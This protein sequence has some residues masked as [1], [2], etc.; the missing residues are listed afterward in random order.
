MGTET[1]RPTKYK[2]EYCEKVIEFLRDGMSK[3]EICRELDIARSTLEEWENNQPLFSEAI[4]KGVELS[5]GWWEK[6]GR[7][8]LYDKDFNTTLWLANMRNRF[9]ADWGV[10]P[11][12]QKTVNVY[13]MDPA[14]TAEYEAAKKSAEKPV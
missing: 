2:K 9:R 4:K 8:A 1:G 11:L 12:S 5:K 7:T 10:D 3:A 14:Q 6:H 13:H